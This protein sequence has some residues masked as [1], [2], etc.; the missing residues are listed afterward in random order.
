MVFAPPF[1]SA[2]ALEDQQRIGKILT[3]SMT[4]TIPKIKTDGIFQVELCGDMYIRLYYRC[5]AGR[6]LL[7]SSSCR[8]DLLVSV[9]LLKPQIFLMYNP[10]GLR[11]LEAVATAGYLDLSWLGG[12]RLLGRRLLH[13]TVRQP[14][15]FYCP[16]SPSSTYP[17]PRTPPM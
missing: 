6:N 7:S 17:S 1:P 12:A 8:L 5:G 10:V 3:L 4:I 9:C 14:Q 15:I 2:S 16:K 11:S 13:P